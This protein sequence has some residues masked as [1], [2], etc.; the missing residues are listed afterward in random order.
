[1]K[2]TKAIMV[3]ILLMAAQQLL[4]QDIPAVQPG[5]NGTQRIPDQAIQEQKEDRM[6]V[7]KNDLPAAMVQLLEN[8]DQYDGWDESPVYFEKNT[9]QYVINVVRDNTTQTF[10]FSK[11]GEAIKTDQPIESS[12]SKQ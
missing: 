2:K 9:D 3:G 12:E 6:E 4:A 5:T 10:R 8:S 11:K 1:M 7:Q